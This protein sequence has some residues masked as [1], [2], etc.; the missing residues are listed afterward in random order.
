M[1]LYSRDDPPRPATDRLMMNKSLRAAG[2]ESSSKANYGFRPVRPTRSTHKG[3]DLSCIR[4]LW[5][6]SGVRDRPRHRQARSWSGA[7]PGAGSRETTG[8]NSPI[9]HAWQNHGPAPDRD[10]DVMDRRRLADRRQAKRR[11]KKPPL[12]AAIKVDN[13]EASNRV[14]RSH[15]VSKP[16]QS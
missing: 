13:R 4:A 11:K 10:S 7:G 2:P 9:R 12:P 6:V 1:P 15:S 16:G 3:G 8:A 5:P 14:D